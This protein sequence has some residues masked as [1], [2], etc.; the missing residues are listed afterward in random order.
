ML[1]GSVSLKDAE[2]VLDAGHLA[3]VKL[4]EAESKLE[5]HQNVRRTLSEARES[6]AW[7]EQRQRQAEIERKRKQKLAEPELRRL[8]EMQVKEIEE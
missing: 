3:S 6:I 2:A 5:I 1:S 8:K 4:R 7:E